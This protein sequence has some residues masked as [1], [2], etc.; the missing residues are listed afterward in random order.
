MLAKIMAFFSALTLFFSGFFSTGSKVFAPPTDTGVVSDSSAVHS[1]YPEFFRAATAVGNIP[2]LK[3]NM[4]PQGITYCEALSAFLISGYYD[5]ASH[6]SVLCIVN[7][8]TGKMTRY[9]TLCDAKGKEQTGHFGGLASYEDNVYAV[10]GTYLYV[11][12][13][14]EIAKRASGKPLTAY[15]QFKLP[16]T[17]SY[18]TAGMGCL[19]IGNFLSEDEA[20]NVSG[21]V[22]NGETLKARL[23]GY[24]LDVESATC[25]TDGT[26]MPAPVYSV[27]APYETQGLAVT[28]DGDFVFSC[29]YGRKNDSHLR[30]Y[31]KVNLNAVN[32]KGFAPSIAHRTLTAPPMTEGM[33]AYTSG[34]VLIF[35]SGASVYRNN[36]GLYPMDK[37]MYIEL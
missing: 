1:A 23:Y 6:G 24:E 36:F 22:V 37:I 29:S 15:A 18:C 25:L 34:V 8:Y 19:W 27:Y 7:E 35:Q 5:N 10:S 30:F 33:T 17:A 32:G 26:S 13:T 31:S 3:E 11:Y 14:N 4:I 21:I 2:G 12:K 20:A 28:D 9:L 16:F